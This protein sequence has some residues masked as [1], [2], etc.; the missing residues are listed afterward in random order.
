MAISHLREAAHL[1]DECSVSFRDFIPAETRVVLEEIQDELWQQNGFC[2]D[3][4]FEI[5]RHVD[6]SADL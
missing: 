1:I 6:Q 2:C 5:L 4:L 3:A